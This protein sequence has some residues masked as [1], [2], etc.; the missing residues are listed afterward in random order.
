MALKRGAAYWVSSLA[1]L[2]FLL[3]IPAVTEGIEGL[4]MNRRA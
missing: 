1:G 4:P 3:A 2:L